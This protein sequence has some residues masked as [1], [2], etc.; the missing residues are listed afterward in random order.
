MPVLVNNYAPWS[1]PA[2]YK[3]WILNYKHTQ[4][5]IILCREKNPGKVWYDRATG[6]RRI[7]YVPSAFDRAHTMEG[8][9]GLAKLLY[10]LGAVEITPAIYGVSWKRVAGEEGNKDWSDDETFQQFLVDLRKA[11]NDIDR[12]AYGTAHQMGTCKM[13][14][15]AASSVVDTKGKVWGVDGL[16][17]ADASVFPTASG[18][19]PMLTVLGFGEW[20]GRR[21]VEDMA[22]AVA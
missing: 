20:I 4:S 6:E 16:Y 14:S 2:G 8:M 19:N 12:A 7:S 1:D 10:T 21:M 15:N 13:G 9:I 5:H 17:V 22:A 3:Q 18:C 11:G